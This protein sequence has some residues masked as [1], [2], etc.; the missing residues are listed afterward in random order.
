MNNYR[1][2]D[3][4]KAADAF[5]NMTNNTEFYG[6]VDIYNFLQY[7]EKP[8]Y[9]SKLLNNSTFTEGYGIPKK[10]FD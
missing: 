10:I 1:L 6:N 8:E 2:K 7:G 9:F 5:D 3:Y 4:A